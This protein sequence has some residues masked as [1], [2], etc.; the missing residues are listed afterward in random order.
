MVECCFLYGIA[1]RCRCRTS[2]NA[3]GADEHTQETGVRMR[4]NHASA[5]WWLLALI[6]LVASVGCHDTD[7]LLPDESEPRVFTGGP[8]TEIRIPKGWAKGWETRDHCGREEIHFRATGYKP[9]PWE[10]YCHNPRPLTT[11]LITG[12]SLIEESRELKREWDERHGLTP[13]GAKSK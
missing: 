3:P 6:V 2:G 8:T 1:V 4:T 7:S 5:R 13:L 12:E 10:S 9:P 11:G